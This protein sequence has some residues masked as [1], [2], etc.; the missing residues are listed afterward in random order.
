MTVPRIRHVRA[1]V[2]RGGG[3]DYHDQPSGHWIDSKIATPMSRYPE[4]R[5][6]RRSFGLN[7]LGTVIV[8]IEADDGS[9]GF[10]PTTGGEL[11]AWIVEKHFARFLEGARVT[12]IEKLW[13]QL[14]LSS[15]FYGRRGIVLNTISAVDIAL[16]DLLG[17]WRGEP[18]YQLLGGAVR[19][20][21]TFYATGPRP[22]IAQR[23]GF[24]GGK[25]P[26]RYSPS[27]GQSGMAAAVAE[28]ELMRSR[29][30]ENFW[31]MLDCWMAL[32]LSYARRL[33]HSLRDVGLYWLEEPFLPDDYWSYRDLRRSLPS[34]MLLAGGE[35]EATRWGFRMMLE[36]ECVDVVQPDVGWCGGITELLKISAMADAAG[37]LVIPHGS[38]VY[39]YHFVVTRHNSPFA[40]FL[41]MHETSEQVVP[42]Y[43][44][45]LLDEP[46]PIAG[47]LVV[48]DRPGFGVR[49]NHD[50]PV[51]RPYTH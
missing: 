45:I 21:L 51:D 2:V 17:Q 44:P 22:D 33:A 7:V 47:R 35:H 20:D 3:A 31:L 5:S 15:V 37:K 26:L 29:V 36:M 18:V 4:Y 41:M 50:I 43:S 34:G 11:S 24:I 9:V 40:E 13:D 19:D 8:E 30:G 49:R 32:D 16:W 27:E 38:S 28:L 39:S 48:P 12:D 6:E 25:L 42:M 10:A 23:L 1:L 46:T 14:F